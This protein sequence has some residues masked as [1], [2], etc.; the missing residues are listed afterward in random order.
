VRVVS[1]AVNVN[2][3]FTDMEKKCS[4]KLL[5]HSHLNSLYWRV[6]G[7]A[8]PVQAWTGSKGSRRLRFLDFKTCI[9][10]LYRHE[11]FLVLISV[12]GWVDPRAIELCYWRIPV[13]PSGIKPMTFQL[14]AQCLY[15]MCYRMPPY[16]RINC[17]R[18]T[19]SK[20]KWD[21]Y[22]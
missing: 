16:C 14:V 12:G 13:T 11:I 19:M 8:I 7:K 3:W 6:K 9:S 22:L 18:I 20:T 15:Q 4:Y 1:I 17:P 10:H 21:H 2:V 5:F